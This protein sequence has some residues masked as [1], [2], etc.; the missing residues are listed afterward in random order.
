VGLR[1]GTYD[2]NVNLGVEGQAPRRVRAEAGTKDLRIQLGAGGKLT[3]RVVLPD[4]NPASG[5]HV[6]AQSADGNGY[7][8]TDEHGAYEIKDLPSGTYTVHAWSQNDGGMQGSAEGVEVRAGQTTQV[9]EIA[10][11]KQ[12]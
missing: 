7:R 8:Q 4:G 3:G 10:V 11:K 12:Q 5:C 1:P 2:V 9:P 6:N